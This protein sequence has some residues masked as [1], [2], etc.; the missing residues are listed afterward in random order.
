LV[1]KARSIRKMDGTDLA[2]VVSTKSI[3][4][5]DCDDPRNHNG[6]PLAV[7][8][9][10]GNLPKLPPADLHVVAYDFGIKH[11]ILRMLTRESCRVTV[12]PAETSAEDVL[13]LNP[14]G[15]FLSNGPGDPEPVTYAH[16]N[17]R[18]LAGKKP[19]F[20]ICLGHQL[21][22]IAL[23]GKTYKLK[24]GH[25][26]GNH[27]I[28]NH[29]TGKVEITAQNHNYNVDPASLPDDVERTHT[30]LN[31]Q[32]LAGLRHKTDPMFSVQY[33]PE[34]SPGPHDSHYLFKDFRKMM[35]EW[36]K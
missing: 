10:D 22:G 36:K 7:L 21:I 32:T 14:D 31:D 30:N 18:K 23:G 4:E 17:I 6:D 33:H 19:I 34:A 2:K 3:Y 1:A 15:I 28:M 16:E 12:V 27:P 5:W 29:Q 8:D 26:G 13:A 35:E 9:E 24:F 11:N 25:H 20:G